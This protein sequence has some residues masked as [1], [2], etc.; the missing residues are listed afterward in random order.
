VNNEPWKANSSEKTVVIPKIPIGNK[1][2][3]SPPIEKA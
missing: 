1:K 3:T 2:D